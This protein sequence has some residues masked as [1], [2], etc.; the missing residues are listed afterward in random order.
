MWYPDL[1]SNLKK[2]SMRF[3]TS[4]R[5]DISTCALLPI[6]SASNVQ[7]KLHAIE[8]GHKLDGRRAGQTSVRPFCIFIHSFLDLSR[9]LYYYKYFNMSKI[10]NIIVPLRYSLQFLLIMMV[11]ILVLIYIE[12]AIRW[13][14]ISYEK[15]KKAWQK[16]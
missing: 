15:E 11:I 8:V 13:P 6:S 5:N 14:T 16:N 1:R 12:D 2:H 3:M 9:Q 7:L 4:M 10:S